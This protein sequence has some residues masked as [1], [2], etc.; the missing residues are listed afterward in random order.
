MFNFKYHADVNVPQSSIKTFCA[1]FNFPIVC[2]LIQWSKD[3]LS[4]KVSV[5]R[6]VETWRKFAHPL[7]FEMYYISTACVLMCSSRLYV[8]I[9]HRHN[10]NL[11]HLKISNLYVLNT[12]EA[13]AR[14]LRS[15]YFYKRFLKCSLV[16]K[17]ILTRAFVSTAS[18]QS[19]TGKVIL[20]IELFYGNSY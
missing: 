5:K 18:L 2:K 1:I 16:V 11:Q 20:N 13:G 12:F 15:N 4:N 3:A 9:T 19:S 8:L 6:R 17:C 7:P 14:L 10:P